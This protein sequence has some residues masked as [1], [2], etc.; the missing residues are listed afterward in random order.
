MLF[1]LRVHFKFARGEARCN[2]V[3]YHSGAAS[4]IFS[5]LNILY[6]VLSWPMPSRINW[7]DIT[8]IFPIIV[9]SGAFNVCKQRIAC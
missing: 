9:S 3:R 8:L 4:I 2:L 6:L 5:V 1:S 7:Y